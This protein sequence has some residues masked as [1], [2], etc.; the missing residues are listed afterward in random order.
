[1]S[2]T[3][4]HTGILI[5]TGK[6]VKEYTQS[7]DDLYENHY[8]KCFEIEGMVYEIKSTE[9]D[10]DSDIFKAKRNANGTID[11]EIKYYNGGCDFNEALD[12]AI[13]NI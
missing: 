5:P 9:I 8:R 6:T 3:E 11:F 10:A 1:M 2:N 13:K 12:A 7:D 4:H